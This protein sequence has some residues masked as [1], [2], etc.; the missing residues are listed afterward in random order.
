MRNEVG[1]KMKKERRGG[2]DGERDM[3]T[4]KQMNIET[5]RMKSGSSHSAKKYIDLYFS[6]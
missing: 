2:G 5:N 6:W 3:Q 4:D 1:G